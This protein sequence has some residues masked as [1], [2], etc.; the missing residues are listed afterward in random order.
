MYTNRKEPILEV[1]AELRFRS[2]KQE[3]L[4]SFIAD[5]DRSLPEG[6][7]KN[8]EVLEGRIRE[9]IYMLKNFGLGDLKL[10]VWQKEQ[11]ELFFQNILAMDTRDDIDQGKFERW[12]LRMLMIKEKL[13]DPIIGRHP[14]V[15]LIFEPGEKHIEDCVSEELA[16]KLKSFSRCANKSTSNGHHNDYERWK[17][18]VIAAHEE[19][20]HDE[21]LRCDRL[22]EWLE[23]DGWE[24]EAA[25][26]LATEYDQG[27]Y[28]LE[29]YDKHIHGLGR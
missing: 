10:V 25:D 1:F 29:E 21:S 11:F 5:F 2:T 8:E 28:L 16:N 12:N 23:K 3:A 17:N 4:D 14:E 24:F 19:G 26:Q 15:E 13:V 18:F 7:S 27:L 22:R 6:W 20:A 9:H